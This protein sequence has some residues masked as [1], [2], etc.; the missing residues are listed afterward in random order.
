MFDMFTNIMKSGHLCGCKSKHRKTAKGLGLLSIGQ[1]LLETSE[2]LPRQAPYRDTS[3]NISLSLLDS[4]FL[5]ISAVSS[6]FLHRSLI[7]ETNITTADFIASLSAS[8]LS[9]YDWLFMLFTGFP[10]VLRFQCL[11][12]FAIVIFSIP[13]CGMVW[14]CLLPNDN[15]KSNILIFECLT[16]QI[17]PRS[18]SN[19]FNIWMHCMSKV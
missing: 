7:P 15:M 16:I 14:Q 8:L 13:V 11:H 2:E 1:S 9:P 3:K 4:W 6:V 19:S 18:F 10:S 5:L 12:L 17:P